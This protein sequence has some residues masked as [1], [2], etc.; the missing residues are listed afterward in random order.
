MEVKSKEWYRKD[1]TKKMDNILA[2]KKELSDKIMNEGRTPTESEWAELNHLDAVY[3]SY[4]E[5]R[6]KFFTE[7][8]KTDY[9]K[10]KFKLH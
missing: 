4:C 8:E 10:H 3:F 2:R 1:I 9:P 6:R 7:P 5:I